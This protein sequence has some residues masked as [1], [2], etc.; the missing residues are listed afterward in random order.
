MASITINWVTYSWRN[1]QVSNNKIIIDWVEKEVNEKTIS[2]HI[3]WDI[4]S[5]NA[6]QCNTISIVWNPSNISTMSG[7]VDVSWQVL[8]SISTM[9]WDVK[10]G[11]I[12]GSVS[13][14][15]W[16]IRNKK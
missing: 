16:D 1:V 7:D 14:M 3:E 10:C 9:S 12:S 2:I 6:D 8:G 11:D 13:T 4:V 5:L 15:S